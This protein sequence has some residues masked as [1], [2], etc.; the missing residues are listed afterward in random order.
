MIKI[1]KR[2]FHV[3]NKELHT[4][5]HMHV[6]QASHEHKN[7]ARAVSKNMGQM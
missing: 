1:A 7:F 2:P 5:G 3:V 4:N 6:V